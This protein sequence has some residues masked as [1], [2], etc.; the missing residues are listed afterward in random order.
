MTPTSVLC[1]LSSSRDTY[2][3]HKEELNAI[4]GSRDRQRRLV[5]LNVVE[6]VAY[7]LIMRLPRHRCIPMR[8]LTPPPSILSLP[9]PPLCLCGSA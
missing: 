3:L 6:Q 2:R 4:E 9:P 5:E 7:A 1:P 8:M